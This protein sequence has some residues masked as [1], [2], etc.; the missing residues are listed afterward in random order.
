MST[1]GVPMDPNTW[2]CQACLKPEIDL[3]LLALSLLPVSTH[4]AH[5]VHP[6]TQTALVHPFLSFIVLCCRLVGVPSSLRGDS[7]SH[8]FPISMLAPHN[9][10]FRPAKR[11]FENHRLDYYITSLFESFNGFPLHLVSQML[12]MV[13]KTLDGVT[14]LCFLPLFA[15]LSLLHCFDFH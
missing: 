5:I 12:R 8:D 3:Q 7:H 9:P 14:P 6:A 11:I 10:L 15:W 4:T 1:T 2:C 13:H